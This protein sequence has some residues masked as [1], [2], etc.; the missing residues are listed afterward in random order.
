MLTAATLLIPVD[1]RRLFLM[2]CIESSPLLPPSLPPSA[3]PPHASLSFPAGEKGRGSGPVSLNHLPL[4]SSCLTPLMN[5]R[6]ASNPHGRT[7]RTGDEAKGL[8]LP[9]KESQASHNE[10]PAPSLCQTLMQWGTVLSGERGELGG[11]STKKVSHQESESESSLFN[12]FF[13]EELSL[14]R[15]F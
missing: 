12:L 7:A 13:A 8:L 3:L 9:R 14:C 11:R 2:G 1:C 6:R 15:L 4:P 5:R 10:R